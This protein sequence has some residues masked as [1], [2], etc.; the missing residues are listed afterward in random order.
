MVLIVVPTDDPRSHTTGRAHSDAGAS[1]YRRAA[2]RRPFLL[3]F[4]LPLLVL[5]FLLPAAAQALAVPL[6]GAGSR[7]VVLRRR[8]RG[9][10]VVRPGTTG[11]P[12]GT[13]QGRVVRRILI[14]VD[15]SKCGSERNDSSWGKRGTYRQVLK[16]R[17]EPG[18]LGCAGGE[19]G[20]KL[21]VVVLRLV[22]FLVDLDAEM[23]LLALDLL[24]PLDHLQQ[25]NRS[26]EVSPKEET[27]LDL[28]CCLLWHKE[29]L[30]IT[31]RPM[32]V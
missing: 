17:Y 6:A 26:T 10:P 28:R 3:Y 14:R 30:I 19:F 8:R 5:S 29:K 13:A 16:Q 9:R 2:R 15:R 20:Q 11:M 22:T 31:V 23:Q 21:P 25:G 7:H 32:L 24:A 12:S 4:V 27:N 18:C 1:G